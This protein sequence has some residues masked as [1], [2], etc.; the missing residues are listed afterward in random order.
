MRRVQGGSVAGASQHALRQMD[1]HAHSS[2]AHLN[3]SI[4]VDGRFSGSDVHGT[5]R[6]HSSR[7]LQLHPMIGVIGRVGLVYILG[8][9]NFS[10]IL[11]LEGSM[12]RGSSDH[13]IDRTIGRLL[14]RI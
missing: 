8:K 9:Y 1:R 14:E 12:G 13:R 5:R 2:I 6:R 11:R 4:L 7:R 3:I 10:K